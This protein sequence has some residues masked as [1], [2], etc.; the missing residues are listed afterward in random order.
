MKIAQCW[1]D[2]VVDDIRLTEILRKHGAKAS[3]NLNFQ[4]HSKSRY[5][6][7]WKFQGTKE[8]VKLAQSELREV[9]D[10]FLVANHSATHP[11][12]TRVPLETAERDIRDGKDALEQHFGYKVTGFAYPFGDH[13]PAVEELV[14]A[15][16]H[17]YARTTEN[18]GRVY[19]PANPMA[20]HPHC[21]FLDPL[22]WER[23]S[24]AKADQELFYFWGHSYELLTNDDWRALEEK[25]ARLSSE[26]E[27][28]N[29]PDLF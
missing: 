28:V 6:G 13:N 1:D 19:P 9:Y 29:L 8:V 11:W 24:A 20:F 10:G 25:I 16:G 22:F 27:W 5:A 4:S 7:E 2:G 18:V 21:H 12:L 23:F 15:T 26:A 14:R 3:F 17:R